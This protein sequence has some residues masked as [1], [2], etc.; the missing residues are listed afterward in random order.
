M[1]SVYMEVF[2]FVMAN[3]RS[4]IYLRNGRGP[5]HDPCGTPIVI[6]LSF[7]S[8]PL[9]LQNYFRLDSYN[10]NQEG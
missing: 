4:L 5:R 1:S 9:T 2:E 6:S 10:I 7:E 8:V 3:G